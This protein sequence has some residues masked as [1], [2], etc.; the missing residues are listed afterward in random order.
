MASKDIFQIQSILAFYAHKGQVIAIGSLFCHL[1]WLRQRVNDGSVSS[2]I[3]FSLSQ[4][5]EEGGCMQFMCVF[6]YICLPPVGNVGPRHYSWWCW[7]EEG[8]WHCWVKLSRV[9]TV[10]RL[11]MQTAPQSQAPRCV[12]DSQWQHTIPVET[13]L[14]EQVNKYLTGPLFPHIEPEFSGSLQI[15]WHSPHCFSLPACRDNHLGDNELWRLGLH[16]D[17]ARETETNWKYGYLC[18]VFL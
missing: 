18:W 11:A 17:R 4:Q 12:G 3:P 2:F 10:P 13:S 5:S 8:H 16:V 7:W 6:M 14:L 1:H 9:G 15:C